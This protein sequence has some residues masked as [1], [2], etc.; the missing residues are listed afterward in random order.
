MNIYTPLNEVQTE[1]DCSVDEQTC[2]VGAEGDQT[3]D[4]IHPCFPWS[5]VDYCERAFPYFQG[6]VRKSR[7]GTGGVEDNVTNNVPAPL[8]GSKV[9]K[10]EA[11][12]RAATIVFLF[13]ICA[14]VVF[15]AIA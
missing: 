9:D 15:A 14:L 10:G 12:T 4:I 7:G 13:V 8:K 5:T 11:G 2:G 1:E 3:V 6:D